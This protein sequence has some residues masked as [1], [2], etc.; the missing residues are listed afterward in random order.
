MKKDNIKDS[1]EPDNDQ[2]PDLDDEFDEE[3]SLD[4]LSQAYAKVLGDQF[5]PTDESP[6]PSGDRQ[7]VANSPDPMESEAKASIVQDVP[8]SVSSIVEAIL[9]VG[10]PQGVKLTSRKIAAVLRD[11][12]PKEVAEAVKELNKKY[13]AENAAYRVESD[14]GVFKM[15][16]ASELIDFQQEFYGRNRHVK[17]S[18]PII[19]VLAVVAYN[20]PVTRDQVGKIRGK[21]SGSL[22]RQLIRRNL[23]ILE[24]GQSDPK[25]KYF[26]TT[27]RFLDLFQ[28]DELADLPQS[29]ESS[30]ISDL[31][32]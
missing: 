6:H 14:G 27:D 9:F 28:L 22:L 26:S 17:L 2:Q 24:P 4:T 15:V 1:I 21:P 29:H 32:D 19:D 18:Q 25:V 30:V 16:L 3:F 23:L 31:A 10:S 5:Q 12:S 7:A 8:I 13:A 20:Q 11:V